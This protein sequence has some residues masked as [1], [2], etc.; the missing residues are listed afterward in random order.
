MN[1]TSIFSLRLNNHCYYI[2]IDATN[3]ESSNDQS[4]NLQPSHKKLQTNQ[5]MSPSS[6]RMLSYCDEKKIFKS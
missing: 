5:Q 4:N 6:P 2:I 3:F 1:K